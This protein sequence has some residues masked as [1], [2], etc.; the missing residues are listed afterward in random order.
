MGLFDLDVKVLQVCI[1]VG[2]IFVGGLVAVNVSEVS[3]KRTKITLCFAKL[4]CVFCHGNIP[5]NY[6]TAER[7]LCEQQNPVES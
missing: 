3:D 6:A 5:Q 1:K 2:P 7:A 4:M